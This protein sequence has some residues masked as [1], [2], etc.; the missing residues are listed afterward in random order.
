MTEEEKM[1]PLDKV[2]RVTCNTLPVP[3]SVNKAHPS[4]FCCGSTPASIKL[5]NKY[6]API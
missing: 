3:C 1:M 2:I 5:S 6:I 4:C